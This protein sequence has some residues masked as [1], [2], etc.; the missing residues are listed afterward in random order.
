MVYSER[1]GSLIHKT[2]KTYTEDARLSEPFIVSSF[3]QKS[4]SEYLASLDVLIVPK[5][6]E[7]FFPYS[8]SD[9]VRAFNGEVIETYYELDEGSMLY[10]E[11]RIKKLFARKNI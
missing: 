10:L 7:N 6:Y 3:N 11:R 4:M 9:A 1:F 5:Y 8:V 2:Y